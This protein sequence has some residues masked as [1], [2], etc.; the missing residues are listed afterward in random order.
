MG[1]HV[2]KHNVCDICGEKFQRARNLEIHKKFHYGQEIFPCGQ[3]ES[4]FLTKKKHRAHVRELHEK[5]RKY[6]CHVCDK[7]FQMKGGLVEHIRT[8]TGE[9][10][11]KCD[12]CGLRFTQKG[13]LDMHI[14]LH[15]NEMP[16]ECI[17]CKAKFRQAGDLKRH[18][19]FH[20][21]G[22]SQED[23]Y[24]SHEDQQKQQQFANGFRN[25]E[26]V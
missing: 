24:N 16:F 15:T 21:C 20:K 2:C 4:L 23:F 22:F 12:H 13:N 10:P 6:Q 26:A 11:Y 18:R 7:R 19:E 8:H 17:A 3:C 25:L 5:E 14:K 1:S 9:K